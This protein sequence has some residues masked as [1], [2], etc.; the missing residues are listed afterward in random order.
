LIKCVV[1]VL[2]VS[3]P[4]GKIC[5]S[6]APILP[7]VDILNTVFQP[8]SLYF[9]TNLFFFSLSFSV[10]FAFAPSPGFLWAICKIVFFPPPNNM[11]HFPNPCDVTDFLVSIPPLLFLFL[12][13]SLKSPFFFHHH[14]H[15]VAIF[16]FFPGPFFHV[17]YPTPHSRLLVS[18]P[19]S[20]FLFNGYFPLFPLG[21]PHPLFTTNEAPPTFLPHMSPLTPGNRPSF[22]SLPLSLQL[23]PAPSR[24][25]FFVFKNTFSFFGLI[26]KET[27]TL[28]PPSP[29]PLR[30][31]QV[32]LFTPFRP[33][34]HFFMC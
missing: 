10:A 23:T 28:P 29:L 7:V 22:P 5:S 18:L 19:P 31:D 26:F 12:S 8:Q 14:G 27:F 6:K 15:G 30:S 24:R 2:P 4:F 17:T 16:F 34:V 20:S 25:H 21:D 11:I 9:I 33:L 13:P 1:V 32:L 3:P